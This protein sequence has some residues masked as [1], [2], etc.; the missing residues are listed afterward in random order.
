MMSKTQVARAAICA[1]FVLVTSCADNAKK[2]PKDSG[3]QLVTEESSASAQVGLTSSTEGMVIWQSLTGERHLMSSRLVFVAGV[4]SGG[5]KLMYAENR[6][7]VF[8]A[9]TTSE[10]AAKLL[11]WQSGFT[12]RSGRIDRND[13]D[14]YVLNVNE[15][16]Q[17]RH[18][19]MAGG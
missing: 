19:M 15:I 10:L 5:Y 11:S 18:S 3:A 7:F 2:M 12:L 4:R 9:E 6:R 16:A 13:S 8:T 17:I 1:S 14:E